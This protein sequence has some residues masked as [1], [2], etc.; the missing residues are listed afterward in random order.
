MNVVTDHFTARAGHYDRSSFW[1]TDPELAAATVAAVA[2][3]P[4]HR[5]LDVACG[6]GLVSRS[7]TGKVAHI[8]G[9]DLTAAMFEQARP[10]VDELVAGKAEDMPFPDASFDRIVCRQG[11]QFMDDRAAVKEM[12]RVLK[13]GGRVVLVHLCAYG[14][15]DRDEYFQVLRLRNPARRNFYL[16]EDLLRLL[17]DAGCAQV[18]LRTHIS[19]EDVDVWSDNK[20]I[21]ESNR[22]GIRE[23]Y[24]NGTPE[25]LRLHGVRLADGRIHDKMLFGIAIGTK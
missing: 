16:R 8:T 11:V 14:P 9:I 10:H 6:T 2:P 24:R 18:E 25:F 17:Q 21:A 4:Q 19:D 7:F 23:I 15:E 22:E 1:C 13:P 20:A 12:L 3:E 5:L